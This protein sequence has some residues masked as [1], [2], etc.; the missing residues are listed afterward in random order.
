M[1]FKVVQLASYLYL[2]ISSLWSHYHVTFKVN[3]PKRR[4]EIWYQVVHLRKRLLLCVLV[5]YLWKYRKLRCKTIWTMTN[6][7]IFIFV[8]MKT[9]KNCLKI[10]KIL[11]SNSIQNYFILP[12]WNCNTIFSSFLQYATYT[13]LR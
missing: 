2:T 5:S 8:M 11:L 13:I 6:C 4:S 7:L 3:I 12:N 1:W 9:K 10:E